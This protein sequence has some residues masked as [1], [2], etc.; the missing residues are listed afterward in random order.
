MNGSYNAFQ[1]MARLSKEEEESSG[2]ILSI[3][4]CS[5][6]RKDVEQDKSK[7]KETFLHR[8]GGNKNKK[9]EGSPGKEVDVQNHLA[10]EEGDP[11]EPQWGR[12]K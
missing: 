1:R 5:T 8:E 9:E 12:E 11:R 3:A 4:D 2:L 10:K 7:A 6:T